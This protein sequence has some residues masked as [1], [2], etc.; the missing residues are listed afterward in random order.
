MRSIIKHLFPLIVTPYMFGQGFWGNEFPELKIEYAPRT[1]VCYKTST[2]MLVDGKLNDPGWVN[3]K[4]SE[5]FFG[6]LTK[7]TPKTKYGEISSLSL[8]RQKY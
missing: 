3:A 8:C 1:Y 2:P 4:W 5:S 6:Q 7:I